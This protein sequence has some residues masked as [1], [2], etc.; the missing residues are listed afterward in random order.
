MTGYYAQR[1]LQRKTDEAFANR[2]VDPKVGNRVLDQM[3]A[4][5]PIFRGLAVREAA[6]FAKAAQQ[7]E[8][9]KN[10][11]WG[12]LAQQNDPNRYGSLASTRFP[13]AFGPRAVGLQRRE[14]PAPTAPS[15]KA[16][17]EPPPLQQ[18]AEDWMGS[19]AP[20]PPIQGIKRKRSPTI[21]LDEEQDNGY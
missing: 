9:A 2:G 12:S 5:R 18:S 3:P 14:A 16:A 7:A 17:P 11:P 19:I 15:P 6:D 20:S 13:T 1:R 21:V 10:A 4:E 8:A